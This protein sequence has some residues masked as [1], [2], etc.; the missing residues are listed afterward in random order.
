MVSIVLELNSFFTGEDDLERVTLLLLSTA[1]D[2]EACR[3]SDDADDAV[4]RSLET[5]FFGL[6]DL[7]CLEVVVEIVSLTVFVGLEV[8]EVLAVSEDGEV[9]RRVTTSVDS[10]AAVLTTV[11][12]GLADLELA[13]VVAETVD[14]VAVL[15]TACSS[16]DETFPVGATVRVTSMV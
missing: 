15:E 1:E 6:G 3:T 10:S 14:D 11:F 7:S 2:T 13:F 8:L 5:V 4:V 9:L 16:F 12:F